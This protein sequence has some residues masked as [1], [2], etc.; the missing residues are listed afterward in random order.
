MDNN[1]ESQT[2]FIF[3]QSYTGNINVQVI[4]DSKSETIRAS[5]KTIAEIFNVDRTAVTQHLSNIFETNELDK[6]SVSAK[7]AHTAPD[8]LCKIFINR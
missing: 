2:N 8:G 6:K 4:L 5:Q 1:I 3:Y 7:I